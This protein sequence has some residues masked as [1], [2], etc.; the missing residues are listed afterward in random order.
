MKTRIAIALLSGAL[1]LSPSL[2]VAAEESD[3]LE[4]LVV[5]LAH[6]SEQ[7]TALAQHFRAKAREARAEAD[8]HAA[9]G[10]SYSAG[11]LIQRMQMKRHCDGLT[12]KYTGLAE[13]YEALAK[14]HEE[15]A[16]GA[17]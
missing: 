17:E 7:H 5:E 8:R 13:E 14:L 3:S 9:M 6:T 1:A 4:Q 16:E 10:R 12:E 15:A 2:A 11:K